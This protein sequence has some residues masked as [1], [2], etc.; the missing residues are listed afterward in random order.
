MRY[1][2][3]CSGIDAATVAWA[4]LGWRAVDASESPEALAA[5]GYKIRKTKKTGKWRV[6]D[7]DGPRY[8]ALGNSFAVPVVR[9]IG[10]R[11]ERYLRLHPTSGVVSAQTHKS[12]QGGRNPR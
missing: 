3:V 4:P 5:A 12:P 1:L 6:N 8:R 7:P 10:E 9:W 2:S 11:I